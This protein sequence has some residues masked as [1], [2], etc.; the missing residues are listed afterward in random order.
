MKKAG[1]MLEINNNTE[2]KIKDAEEYARRK[3]TEVFNC[4]CNNYNDTINGLLNNR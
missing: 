1:T 4:V 2:V 3:I